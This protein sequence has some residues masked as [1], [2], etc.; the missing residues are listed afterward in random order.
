L[1]G[2]MKYRVIMYVLCFYIQVSNLAEREVEDD[3]LKEVDD[4]RA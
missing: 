3:R 2:M 4:A 1:R